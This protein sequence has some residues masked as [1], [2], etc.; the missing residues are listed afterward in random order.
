MKNLEYAMLNKKFKLQHQSR[1]THYYR[2]HQ[3]FLPIP[4]IIDCSII[5]PITKWLN[6]LVQLYLRSSIQWHQSR[7]FLSKLL[8]QSSLFWLVAQEQCL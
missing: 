5:C 8:F 3:L 7:I 1:E 2:W 4:M 6:V